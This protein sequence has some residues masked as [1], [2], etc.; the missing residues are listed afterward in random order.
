M[1]F[2]ISPGKRCY[3]CVDFLSDTMELVHWNGK[4]FLLFVALTFSLV[5]VVCK[6]L[7]FQL[8]RN[9]NSCLMKVIMLVAAGVRF[10]LQITRLW[11]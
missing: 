4:S 5:R 11:H 9:L 6:L 1:E 7:L 3:L 8:A 10:A 2:K